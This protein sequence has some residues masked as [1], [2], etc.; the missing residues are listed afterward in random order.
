MLWIKLGWRNLWRNKSRTFVQ[1]AVIAGSLFFAIWMHNLATGS[2]RK[3]V[4]ESIKMGSGH[5][6]FHHPEYLQ[7]RRTELVF[8]FDDA[9][10]I[11]SGTSEIAHQ[12]PRLTIPSLVR[13]SYENKSAI[14]MGVDFQKEKLINPLLGDNKRITGKLPE[15]KQIKRAYIGEKL[16]E[17]LRVKVGKKIVVMFQDSKGKIASKLFRI[18]GTFKSGVKQLDSAMIY[19]DRKNL[20]KAFGD[21]NAI[22]EMAIILKDLKYKEQV[23][24]KL[25]QSIKNK[26]KFDVYPWEI[27][28][29]QVADLIMLDHAQ[30]KVMIALLYFLVTVGTVNLLL[31]SVLER[32]REFGLLQAMGLERSKIKTMIAVESIVLGFLGSTIGIILSLIGCGYTWYYGLDLSGLFEAQEVAGM[33]FEPVINSAWDVPGMILLFTGMI[34]LVYIASIYPARKALKVKPADAMRKY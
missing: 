7:E 11:A 21:K 19:V 13:S 22:H 5:M 10:K 34:F 2:Y 20:A 24:N 1:L 29:K 16:S 9:A 28:M 18:A 6:S 15:G 33:L 26:A 14:L 4:H 31:M 17:S 23:F 32:T 25:S 8:N 30:L 12:L 27:T 3:M